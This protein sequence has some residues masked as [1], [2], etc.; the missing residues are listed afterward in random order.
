MSTLR[1]KRTSIAHVSVCIGC[2][3]GQVE[4]G[5]P[6]VPVAWLKAQWKTRRLLK[7]V[8]LS[9]SGCLGPCDLTNVASIGHAGGAVWLGHLENIGHYEALVD[10]AADVAA[11]GRLLPLPAAL[12]ARAFERFEQTPGVTT[13][14]ER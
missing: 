12:K 13:L 3:C 10:W 4:K 8:Q 9:I 5:H 2:C 11:R 6:D 14:E 1:T 7:H